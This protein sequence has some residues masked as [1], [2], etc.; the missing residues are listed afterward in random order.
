ML[1]LRDYNLEESEEIKRIL[2]EENI[3]DLIIAD[4]IYVV[5][6]NNDL[7]GISKVEKEDD[8]FILKYL[9]IK[10]ER[11]GENLGD[12][13]LRALLSKLDNQGIE[14]IYYKENNNYLLKK[15]FIL[16]ENNQL[17]LNITSF[18]NEGCKCSGGCNVL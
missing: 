9:V 15:G 10:H 11:R 6:D 13:L 18:F 7:I 8:N 16:N 12:A 4:L 17:E 2:I 3:V 1:I 14:K 5:L